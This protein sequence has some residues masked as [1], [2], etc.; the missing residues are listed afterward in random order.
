M[1]RTAVRGRPPAELR[2]LYDAC[3]AAVEAGIG[4]IRP[5]A[6]PAHVYDRV[7]MEV[8]TA[9]PEYNIDYVGHGIG[10]EM[11]D[12][13]LLSRG[14]SDIYGLAAGGTLEEGMVLCVEVPYQRFGFGGVQLEEV[15]VVTAHGARS[16]CR[17]SRE[18]W[19]L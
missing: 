16:L 4:A 9:I 10:L 11:Y 5:G 7:L 19:E 14:A 15:V 2:S 18:L 17:T 3:R 8:R 12:A 6:T 1:G 13:P